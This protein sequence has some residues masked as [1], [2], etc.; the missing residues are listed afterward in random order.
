MFEPFKL[1]FV[2]QGL[3]ELLLLAVGAGILGTWIVARGLSFYTHGVAAATFPGLVAADG[4]GVSAIGGAAVAAAL[5]AVVVGQFSAR[6]QRGYDSSTGLAL[7][8][9][10]AVGVI[11]AS[12]VFKSG[13][14]VETLL[15]GSLL[16]ISDQD[17]IFAAIVSVLILA[18]SWLLAPRWLASALEPGESRTLGLRSV[19]PDRVLLGLIAIAAIATLSALGVLLSAALLVVPAA[20][21][22]FWVKR[23]HI[24]QIV[25]VALVAVEGVIGLWLSVKVNIPPGAAIAVLAGV[26]FAFSAVGYQTLAW[27]RRQGNLAVALAPATLVLVA[28]LASGCG[29]TSSDSGSSGGPVDVV[30]TT[31]QLGDFVREVGGSDVDVHQILAPNSDPHDY[32]PRP[33]DVTATAGASVVFLSG[34][35]IDTWMDKVVEQAGGDPAKITI[36]PG[37]TPEKVAGETS[38][39]EASKYDPHW[40]H[41]PRNAEAAVITIRDALIKADPSAKARLQA[42]TSAYLRKLRALD[43]GIEKCFAQVPAAQRKLVTSHDA[44]NYFAKR[45]DIDVVGAVIPSQTTQAQPSAGALATLV[46]LVEEQHVKAIFPESSINPKLAQSLAD[47]TGAKASYTLYGDTLGSKGSSGETYL[48]M[49]QANANAMLEGFSAGKDRCVVSGAQ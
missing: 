48:K 46:K 1:P 40:W 49:E 44:F 43:T 11:L 31:T 19:W 35:N 4:L 42:N 16:V 10:M 25:T 12:D 21:T 2:Q 24:W 32:E 26:F 34:N 20:T 23:M 9:A 18:A 14:S 6:E 22:R 8:G 47:Q 5:F 39:A 45:Y 41:D 15:F 33:K 17:V 30:A 36:A 29:S 28:L 37:H 7:V 3:W 27:W 13:A 38:G